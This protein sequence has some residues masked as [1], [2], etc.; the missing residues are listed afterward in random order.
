MRYNILITG[1]SG[2]LGKPLV[3]KLINLKHNVFLLERKNKKKIKF[4]SKKPK[5]IIFGN[6]TNKN[7]IAKII[8][9][10]KINVV[11]HLGAITQVLD[12]LKK[13]YK[14]Y[15]TNI[16]G[17]INLLEN[18]RAINKKI[19]FIYS[20]SDKAYGEV[21]NR[22]EYKEGNSLDPT[23]PYDVS[24]S[25]SDLICQSYSK[26]YS[27]KVGVIRSGN[28]YGPGDFNLKRL[29][30]EVILSTIENKNFIIRSDGKSTRDYVFVEDVVDAYLRLFN[31]LKK[32]K[33]KLKIYNVSS[34]F[35]YSALEIAN[36]IIKK[37]DKVKLK[38]VILNN[39]K[40]ELNFQRLNYSKIQRELKW[41]PKTNFET[42]IKKTIE[43]YLK[44]YKFLRR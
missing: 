5:K 20:S 39:S 31:Y 26:T 37:M 33:D 29:I 35:N 15:L 30:P 1:G 11:F 40:Q 24:K 19:I 14:T 21:R 23:Y 32:S 2:F 6:F 41:R 22:K 18:I 28:I 27:I 9:K 8:K 3:L 16:M 34:R 13:P 4:L 7:L 42:G 10:N 36:M 17:T 25:S 12:S 43:W 38:P 44:A